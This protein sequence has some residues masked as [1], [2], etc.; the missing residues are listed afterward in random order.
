MEPRLA[1]LREPSVARAMKLFVSLE[2]GDKRW[3]V[4]ASDG[5]R[6]SEYTVAA[7]DGPGLLE[8]L[9][10]ARW[11]F[12]LDNEAV[13]VSCYEAGR[14]GFWL[15]RFLEAHGVR[16]LVVDAASIEVNRRQRRAKTDR[17]D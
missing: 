11:R 2:L 8:L 1:A 3:Q 17:L 6:V 4:A 13:V 12:G 5:A 9:E 10:R 15:H 16:S 14:D 7:G